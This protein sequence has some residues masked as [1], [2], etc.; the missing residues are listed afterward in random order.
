[1]KKKS[2]FAILIRLFLFLILLGGVVFLNYSDLW[3]KSEP[4]ETLSVEEAAERYSEEFGVEKNWILAIIRAES[5]FDE[6][7]VSDTGQ[8]G[9]MQ[10]SPTLYLREIRDLLG[11]GNAVS[12]LKK[13]AFNIRCGTCLFS[14]F[15]DYFN[16]PELALAAYKAGTD[17]VDSWIGDPRYAEAGVLKIEELPDEQTRVFLQDAISYYEELNEETG[18]QS[19]TRPKRIGEKRKVSPVLC[20]EWAKKYG[21]IYG[22]DPYLVIAMVQVESSFDANACSS[23][24]AI[25][26][27]QIKRSTYTVDIKANLQLDE[28]YETLYDP[29]FSIRCCAY[30]ASWL[31]ERVKRVGNGSYDQI[32][33]A[34]HGGINAVRG[35][36]SDEAY[37]RDGELLYDSIQSVDD[38]TVKHVKKIEKAYL[39]WKNKK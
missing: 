5:R 27:T 20:F 39:E 18:K 15:I 26:L 38:M 16:E 31:E 17:T 32:A 13:T 8:I 9:L 35:W 37:S 1:M 2:T 3:L 7:A 30:Y 10:I 19:V 21:E 12:D 33:A 34:Y 14:H 4:V 28:P 36:F 25:G 11:V 23:S 6:N 29:E 22:I 24:G